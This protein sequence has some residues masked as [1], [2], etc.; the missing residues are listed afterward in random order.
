MKIALLTFWAADNYGAVLQTYATIKLLR[1]C[2]HDVEL[3]NYSIPSPPHSWI[4]SLLLFPKHLKFQKFRKKYFTNLTRKYNSL[5][6]L[7]NAPPVADC[8]LVGSDQ[9]WNPDLTKD[10][11]KSFFLDFGAEST[12]RVSYASSFGLSTWNDTEWISSDDVKAFL[13]RFSLLSVRESYGCQILKDTFGINDSYHVLDPVMMFENYQELTGS[14]CRINEIVLYKFVGS[15]LFYQKSRDIGNLLGLSVRSIGSIRRIK[16]IKS[17]YPESVENWIK[18]IA[19]AK[20][21]ITD[22]FHGTVL[23]LLYKKQFIVWPGKRVGRIKSLLELLGLS[24]RIISE[25]DTVEQMI[26]CLQTPIDYQNIHHY[27]DELRKQ[28]FA[29]VSSI[30]S[31]K[32]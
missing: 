20:F 1:Q 9:T 7:Q 16:G 18:R 21:I 24:D 3:V 2:G 4:K 17:S 23:S 28:S 10:K 22:S 8:Y 26:G 11:A 12:I 31:I 19:G 29:F 15:D 13:K 30:K 27:L 32:R 5:E 6:A 14:F 25:T